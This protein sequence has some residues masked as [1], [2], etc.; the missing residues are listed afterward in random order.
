M[1]EWKCRKCGKSNPMTQKECSTSRCREWR[2]RHLAPKRK[3]DWECCGEVQFASRKK[4]RK[5]DKECAKDQSFCPM[6]R[7]KVD[8]IINIY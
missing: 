1:E 3:G 4:C 8:K 5:C 2:P 7:G 6:C